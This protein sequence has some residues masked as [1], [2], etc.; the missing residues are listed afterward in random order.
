MSIIS[1]LPKFRKSDFR[2]AHLIGLWRGLTARP[3]FQKTAPRVF[4]IT[5]GARLVSV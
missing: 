1:I 2:L 5:G 4:G 3:P